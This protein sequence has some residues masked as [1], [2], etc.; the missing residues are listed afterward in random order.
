MGPSQGACLIYVTVL[1]FTWNHFHSCLLSLP[2][3]LCGLAILNPCFGEGQANTPFCDPPAVKDS[4]S[5]NGFGKIKWSVA[6][7]RKSACVAYKSNVKLFLLLCWRR[8]LMICEICVRK[9]Q[10]QTI[11][12]AISVLEEFCL[13][14]KK[15]V[16]PVQLGQ[17]QNGGICRI[18]SH[19][20]P[21]FGMTAIY[22]NCCWCP[23]RDSQNKKKKIHIWLTFLWG[24][25]YIS[26]S[27]IKF[28]SVPFI[29][30]YPFCRIYKPSAT[31]EQKSN[32]SPGV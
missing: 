20:C 5:Q 13:I 21:H 27:F 3:Q 17:L 23:E 10:C 18:T 24:S 4:L 29:S 19:A 25:I 30:V 28:H 15:Y 22:S 11:L 32:S 31:K 8:L 12:V 1:W 16:R 26:C 9:S 7:A 14:T 2:K 6:H